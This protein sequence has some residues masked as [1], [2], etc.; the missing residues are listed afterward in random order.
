MA[1]RFLLP[2]HTVVALCAL[3][4]ALV[5]PA[6][7]TE[8]QSPPDPTKPAAAADPYGRTTPRGT[9][10]G[11]GQAVNHQDASA[12][13]YLQ[14][15]A[16]QRPQAEQ[17]ARDLSGLIERYFLA[18]LTTL[19][20]VPEGATTDGLPLD[21]ERIVLTIGRTT[22]D[23]VLVRVKDREAGQIWL[24]SSQSV[25]QIRRLHDSVERTRLERLLPPRM[26]S[27]QIAG[28][29]LARVIAWA[30]T[31]AIPFAAFW[32]LSVLFVVLARMLARQASRKLLESGYRRVRWPMIVLLTLL[33][34]GGLIRLLGFSLQFRLTYGRVV[35]VAAAVTATWLLWRVMALSFSH[36]RVMAV[37]AGHSGVQSLLLLAERVC[38]AL[39]VLLAIF[40]VLT[41][42]GV[43]TGTA[44]A[45]VGL[46]GVAVAL[47]AQKSVENL[48]G[49]VFLLS[50]RALAVGDFCTIS[51]RQGVVEDITMRS[52][53]LRT[54]EQTLLSVPTG[55]LSQASLENF[56]SRSKILM[57]STLRLRYGTTT[58]Q[59][60]WVLNRIHALLEERTDIET[61]TARIRLVDFAARAIELELFAYALTPDWMKFLAIR[62]D[63]LLQ[64]ATIVESSGTG[65]AQP[66]AF[67]GPDGL[68]L[69]LEKHPAH[70]GKEE[71][72]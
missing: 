65:F 8:G 23:I 22:H 16:A 3:V 19:S 39:L 51:D 24:V 9:I 13:R 69:F 26:A 6:A 49:G 56:A 18:P 41:I 28:V 7:Q 71:A 33:V 68:P 61:A 63:L 40:V 36:A 35:L 46:G 57:Q 64:I 25:A 67:D 42:V 50:D 14:L 53:R 20:D 31:L 10:T 38:K 45:G 72:G 15:T 44:L 37:R 34:H 1:G 32:L 11:L 47:G 55:V 17:L 30:A 21:R 12:V 43:D 70:H 2:R 52:V 62:E 59:L 48:L 29:S 4:L 5:A 27:A 58:D 66:V 54:L 60:R